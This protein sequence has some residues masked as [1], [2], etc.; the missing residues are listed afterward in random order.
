MFREINI[1]VLILNGHGLKY[2]DFKILVTE[3]PLR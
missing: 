1:G 2:L 3:S